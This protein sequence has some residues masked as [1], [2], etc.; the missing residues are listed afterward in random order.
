ML[1]RNAIKLQLHCQS[2][3]TIIQ[4][5]ELGYSLIANFSLFLFEQMSWKS[6]YVN[7]L[8]MLRYI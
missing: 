3:I 2:N 7:Y 5:A 4:Q 8:H 6:I 1:E